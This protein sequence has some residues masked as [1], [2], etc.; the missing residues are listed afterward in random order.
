[1]S[2][3]FRKVAPLPA[4]FLATSIVGFL[5]SAYL[6]KDISW[7]LTLLILFATMFIASFISATKA[8]VAASALKK[9]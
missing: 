5:T 9:K 3:L 8:P 4:S 2:L 7:K 6:I 1:M